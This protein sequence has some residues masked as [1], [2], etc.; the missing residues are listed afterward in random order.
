MHLGQLPINEFQAICGLEA[1]TQIYFDQ[2]RINASTG[3]DVRK[4]KLEA[5]GVIVYKHN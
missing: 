4:D 2:L 3:P 5:W 1:L